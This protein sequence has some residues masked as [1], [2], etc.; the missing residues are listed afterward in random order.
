VRS[1]RG[2]AEDAAARETMAHRALHEALVA[3]GQCPLCGQAVA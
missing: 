1:F 3:A 2:Q